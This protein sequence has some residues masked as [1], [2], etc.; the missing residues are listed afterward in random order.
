M[1]NLE[2]P[3]IWKQNKVD[4]W[5]RK[6]TTSKCHYSLLILIPNEKS[7]SSIVLYGQGHI[8]HTTTI[9]QNEWSTST[10]ST[11]TTEIIILHNSTAKES[12]RFETRV[13]VMELDKLL[14]EFEMSI[15][16]TKTIPKVRPTSKKISQDD[17]TSF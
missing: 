14:D 3:L 12:Q 6:D 2:I 11:P 7:T 15:K 17:V 13:F 8:Y 16:D 9:Y 1:V 4:F 10:F 5:L